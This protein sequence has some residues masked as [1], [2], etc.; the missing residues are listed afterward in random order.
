[1]KTLDAVHCQEIRPSYHYRLK[2]H[3]LTYLWLDL[4]RDFLQK[5]TKKE[6]HSHFGNILNTPKN[7][8]F[9]RL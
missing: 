3:H 4:I 2:Y 1:M 5:Y 9:A 7:H 6:S 8:S